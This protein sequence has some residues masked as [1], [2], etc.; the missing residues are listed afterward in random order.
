[1]PS[2]RSLPRSPNESII[3]IKTGAISRTW[4]AWFHRLCEYIT[5]GSI[6]GTNLTLTLVDAG[7]STGPVFVA[8][9]D[10]SSPAAD[11]N[12][13]TY[14]FQGRNDAGQAVDYVQLKAVI[15]DVSD[16]SEDGHFD[17]ETFVAGSTGRRL[18]I[19]NGVFTP[20]AS[21]GDKGADTINASAVY[22][23]GVGPLTDYVLEYAHT[24]AV[25]LEHWEESP[26]AEGFAQDRRQYVD[27]IEATRAFTAAHHHLP[28][29]P[30]T[31]LARADKQPHGELIVRLLEAVEIAQC[32]IFQ[33]NRRVAELEGGKSR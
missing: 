8:D 2:T 3:D 30:S 6:T 22:D 28:S 24:G 1:M 33:L 7:S 26:W 11:D 13:G 31:S 29:M 32:H 5:D 23:D 21:G 14:Q 25:D 20:N 27:S 12:I 15:R 17:V 16:G 19:R 9:R 10:S 4:V 18:S